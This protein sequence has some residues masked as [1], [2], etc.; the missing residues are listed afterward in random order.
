[1]LSKEN[2]IAKC[3]QIE[4]ELERLGY[5][6]SSRRTKLKSVRA[7]I[8]FLRERPESCLTEAIFDDF[9]DYRKCTKTEKAFLKEIGE[10]K[11]IR[12]WVLHGQLKLKP[13]LIN[14][15]NLIKSEHLE[16][17]ERFIDH[18]K[19]NGNNEGGIKK[20][21]GSVSVF[22]I[23]AA[24]NDINILKLSRIN[25]ENFIRRKYIN[26]APYTLAGDISCVRRFYRWLY[27][28]NVISTQI[29]NSFPTIRNLRVIN[30]QAV[31]TIE[32]ITRLIEVIN[33]NTIKGKRDYAIILLAIQ[34]GMRASDIENLKFENIN[35][36]ENKIKF[37]QQK[38][39]VPNELNLTKEVGWAIIRYIES[40]P[41]VNP[42]DGYIFRKMKPPFQRLT[43]TS[44]S[45]MTHYCKLAGIEYGKGLSRRS[46]HSLR[47]TLATVMLESGVPLPSITAVLGHSS[48]DSTECYLDF[49]IKHLAECCLDLKEVFNDIV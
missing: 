1:M 14:K 48:I 5:T 3:L 37:V 30:H 42:D 41:K 20:M 38:T 28:E 24:E 10:V 49:D 7:F 39:G 29:D 2:V 22:L 25:I 18:L 36:N 21:I 8:S 23:W 11:H 26:K 34:L 27:L 33:L 31:W 43:S 17:L 15:R 44:S 47:H 4:P 35:W 6:S 45:M 40:R 46:L 19:E 16:L 9:L 12:N 32:E 13:D